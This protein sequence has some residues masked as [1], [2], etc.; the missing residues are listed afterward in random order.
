MS[1]IEQLVQTLK[2]EQADA[3]WVSNP[4]NIFYFTGYKSEPHERLFALLVK[5][6][7]Q[8]IL[9]CPQLEVEEVKASPF[10]GQIIG[11]LDTEDP[12]EQHREVY[13]TLLIEENHLT[14][15]RY[16]AL[17]QAFSVET[18]GAADP[19]IR[20]L[21]NIKTSQEIDTLREAAKLADKCLEIGVA[22]L[23]EGVTE[24]EVVN[25]IENEIKA[26]GVDQ[27]SF[28]TMVLFGD[29][30]AAPHGTPG[31]RRLKKDEFVLFDLGVV[32]NHYCSDITRT[33]AFGQPHSEAEK[34]Y[35]IVLEAEQAAIKHIQ[36]GVTI[37]ELDDIARGI[38][39]DAGYGDYF[40]HRLGHGLGLEAHEYQDISSTNQNPLEPGMVL[41]IEPGIYVPGVAGVRIEDDILVTEQGFEV[42]SGYEK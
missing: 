30:A 36:P 33:V 7:G 35:N 29:H 14:V 8:Q 42:L 40:P 41:T 15:Q 28:D 4:I 6:D 26:F 23:K 32:Y 22:F 17:Q 34:I 21:R 2:K 31:E 19:V 24:R 12:F 38:I 18:F 39:T 9:F 25:H 5:A 16:H 3:V 10:E 11:Y 37:R 1:K 27:M 20:Q 13:P